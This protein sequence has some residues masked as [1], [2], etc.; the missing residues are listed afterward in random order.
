MEKVIESLVKQNLP[1]AWRFHDMRESRIRVWNNV[2]A[3]YGQFDILDLE[4][5]DNLKKQ[6]EE[7]NIE[8]AEA[9]DE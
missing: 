2:M 8:L 3:D 6:C 9:D 5:F 1:L 7:N 4:S